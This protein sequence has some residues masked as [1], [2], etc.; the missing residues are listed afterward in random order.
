MEELVKYDQNRQRWIAL[1]ELYDREYWKRL[2]IIQEYPPGRKT[3]IYVGQCV[4]ETWIFSKIGFEIIVL[5]SRSTI[6]N[7]RSIPILPY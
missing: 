2:W 3:P 5:H 4:V 6:K 7:P 1:F